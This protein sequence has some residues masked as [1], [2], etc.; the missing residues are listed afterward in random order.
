MTAA[1]LTRGS[2]PIKSVEAVLG[3]EGYDVGAAE[4]FRYAE[5]AEKSLSE[6]GL[7]KLFYEVEQPL[8]V[9]LAAMEERGI[10]VD[11]ERL[12]AL[13]VKYEEKLAALTSSIYA[14]AGT[15]FNI[16]SPKQLGEVLFDKLGLKHGKRRRRAI[17]SARTC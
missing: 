4:M 15:T 5:E 16:A 17:P 12:A 13:K 9:V 11:T 8:T 10:C 3:G 1:H 14:A 7:D 2:A 6:Q